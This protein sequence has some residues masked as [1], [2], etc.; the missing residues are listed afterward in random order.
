MFYEEIERRDVSEIDRFYLLFIPFTFLF[1]SF[2]F[3][4]VLETSDDF[5]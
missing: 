1:F 5:A 3:G 2:F 4:F